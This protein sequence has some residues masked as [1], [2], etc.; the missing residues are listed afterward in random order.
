M[1]DTFPT[2]QE[3]SVTPDQF[4]AFWRQAYSTN[5]GD[6]DSNIRRGQSLTDKNLRKLMEW[7]AGK[8]FAE[9]AGAWSARVGVSEINAQRE[10]GLSLSDGAVRAL[11]GKVRKAGSKAKGGGTTLIWPLF[12]CHVADPDGTPIYDV[13]TWRATLYVTGAWKPEYEGLTPVKLDTYLEWYRPWFAK[14]I[15]G[16]AFSAQDL[17][18]ALMAFGQF[19]MTRWWKLL[20]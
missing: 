7:K 5:P 8:R 2:L 9:E 3:P 11:V 4:V 6:Y 14:V 10:R 16:A 17:D 18:K 19:T 13:N 1:A 20:G 15:A 12:I